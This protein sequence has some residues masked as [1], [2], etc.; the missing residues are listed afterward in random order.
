MKIDKAIP[1]G[2]QDITQQDIDAVVAVLQSKFLTQ[3]PLVKFVSGANSLLATSYHKHWG[4]WIILSLVALHVAAI[5][6]YVFKKKQNLVSAMVLGDKALDTVSLAS[7]P[8][9]KDG[10]AQRITAL[11]IFIGIA[12]GVMAIATAT[13]NSAVLH[14]RPRR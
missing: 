7:V 6:F 2:T 13:G 10:T 3:G 9:S 14:H 11:L 8:S 12:G 4:K 1:Y 5:F